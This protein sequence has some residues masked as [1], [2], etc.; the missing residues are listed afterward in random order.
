MS[1]VDRQLATRQRKALGGWR[2]GLR[3][4]DAAARRG[5]ESRSLICLSIGRALLADAEK[6]G[7]KRPIGATSI[8]PLLP[9]A[10]R[11]HDDGLLR[12]PAARRQPRAAGVA[13]ARRTGSADPGR[14]HESAARPA[15]EEGLTGGPAPRQ[16]GR[17][18]LGRGRRRR[19]C[20]LAEAGLNVV[21][22]EKGR[23]HSPFEERKDDLV[24]QRNASLGLAYG[25]D[26]D[27]NPRVFVDPSG[28]ERVVYPK[29]GAYQA[30]ASCVGGGTVSYGGQA[31]RYMPQDFRMRSTY[32]TVKARRSKTGRSPTTTWG[33]ITSE[34]ST[35]S[36]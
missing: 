10:A 6:G 27:K 3:G 26:A 15:D 28:Q 17:R 32:G 29:D 9:P 2:A 8:P 31:W 23:W 19:S 21:V 30:N 22:L 35:R 5:R 16:R 12:R 11:P 36:G 7:V 14:L 25:P 18:R 34:P 33:P 4:L 1:F 20:V 24:N 13:D